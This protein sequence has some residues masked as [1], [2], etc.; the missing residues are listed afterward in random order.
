MLIFGPTCFFVRHTECPIPNFMQIGQ[1]VDIGRKVDKVAKICNGK[2]R[3]PAFIFTICNISLFLT[4]CSFQQ[5]F[6]V[7]NK[8]LMLFFIFYYVVSTIKN[9]LCVEKKFFEI[10][11]GESSPYVFFMQI[12]HL[13]TSQAYL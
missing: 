6:C 10:A 2:S 4:F 11:K 3:S 7:F 5:K 13:D 1:K 8:N 12:S 9:F